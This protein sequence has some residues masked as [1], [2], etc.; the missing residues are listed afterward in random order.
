[1]S[2][3]LLVKLEKE[4]NEDALVSRRGSRIYVHHGVNKKLLGMKNGENLLQRFLL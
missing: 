3:Q 1:M 4:I 2:S